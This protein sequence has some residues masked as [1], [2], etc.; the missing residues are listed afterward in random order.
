MINDNDEISSIAEY[1]IELL[2]AL[3]AQL[4]IYFPDGGLNNFDV[5]DPHKMPDSD[6]YVALRTYGLTKIKDLNKYFKIV[7]DETIVKEGQSLLSEIVDCPNYCEMRSSQT[8]P[9]A[10]WAQVLKCKQIS[11]GQN[12]KRLLHIVLSIPI[13]S[14]EAERG[15]SSLKY[16]RDTHRSRL[17][18]KNLDAILRIKINGPDDLHH[19]AAEK[20]AKKWIDDGHLATDNK[21]GAK[22]ISYNVASD[23]EL[24]MKKKI[25]INS[26]LF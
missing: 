2:T 4:N 5:F 25:L 9:M 17:M 26:T 14:A 21:L 20:Y 22:S 11:W 15:F 7:G 6:N 1:R 3:I 24:D 16:I 12:I 13:S 18:P 23:D 19:F 10:F 8:S